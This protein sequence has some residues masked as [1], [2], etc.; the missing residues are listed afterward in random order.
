MAGRVPKGGVTVGW[1]ARR[2]GGRFVE[3]L[4][5]DV[6]AVTQI[7]PRA[8][9]A[10]LVVEATPYVWKPAESGGGTLAYYMP[11]QPDAHPPIA[12]LARTPRGFVAVG[13]DNAWRLE[14]TTLVRELRQLYMRLESVIA[15]PGGRA[16]AV[17]S[18]NPPGGRTGGVALARDP[19]GRWQRELF[20]NA[21]PLHAVT[22]CP[23]FTIAAGDGG[24][25]AIRRG[26]ELK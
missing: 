5:E 25:L 21:E 1:V 24:V 20:T 16:V 2:S 7:L 15:L 22:H 19:R 10:V 12:A 8:N 6:P 14:G 26:D 17:G 13:P 11:A 3:R 9:D 18:D 4:V 23:P